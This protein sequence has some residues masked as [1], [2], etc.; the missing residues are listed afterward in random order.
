M[1]KPSRWL[2]G[3]G[4]Q[5]LENGEAYVPAVFDAIRN[6]RHE[7]I[8]ETFIVFEDKVGLEL[9][10]VLLQAAQRGVQVDV[11][12]DGFGS[13]DLTESYVQPLVAAG[14][15]LRTFDPSVRVF[16]KRVNVLRRMHRKLVVVD[17]EQA[18]VGGINFSADHLADFG[19]EAKQDYAVQLQGPIVLEIRNFAL[20]AIGAGQGG[21]TRP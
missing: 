15:R 20:A 1:R 7:V 21:P 8:V 16:G 14:V 11:M 2:S 19:P 12:V 5:L 17:G 6:A 13:A 9:H 18:F 4:V 10:A 3:N